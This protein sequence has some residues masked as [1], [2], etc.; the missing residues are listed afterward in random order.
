[1]NLTELK[2]QLIEFNQIQNNNFPQVDT[3]NLIHQ[4]S[5]FYDQRLLDIWQYFG[6]DKREDL[7]L[8]AV[9]GYGRREM[10]PL[11][12]LDI[13]VLVKEPLDEETQTQFNAFFTL[14]WDLKLQVG[15]AIRTFDECI[16]MGKA[17]ISIA[18]NMLEGRFLTGNSQDFYDL[19]ERIHQ[20]DFWITEDFL[21]AKITEKTERYARYHNTSYNL[22]PDL[23]H[24]PG[25]LRDLHLLMWVMLRHYGVYSLSELFEQQLL[26]AEEYSELEQAQA[27][28]FKMRF[29]LHLQLKRYDNRLRFD[30]QLVLSQRLGYQ[31]EGNQ[32]V[33]TMMREYFQATQSIVQLS[34]L[35]LKNFEKVILK[36]A[37]LKSDKIQLD[38]HFYLQNNL[39][40]GT[41]NYQF[42]EDEPRSILDLFYHL[43]RYPNAK[44]SISALRYLRLAIGK[45]T[46]PLCEYSQSRERFISLFSQPNCI[47]RAIKP[48]HHLG[49]LKAYL[50]QWKNITGLMQFNMLH[51]YTVD[52]H[53]IR[54]MQKLEKLLDPNETSYPLCSELFRDFKDPSV[55]YLAAMFHDIAKGQ[56]GCHSEKGAMEVY[57]FA[58]LHNLDDEQTKLMTWLVAEHLTMSMTAQRRDIY[59]PQVISEFAKT[60][61][62]HTA[63]SAL[64]CL[65]FADMSSTNKT[66]WNK[67][68]EQLFT[69]LY[70]ATKEQIERGEEQCIDYQQLSLVNRQRVAEK[71]PAIY[72]EI[73]IKQINTFWNSC[74][75]SYFIR[76][77][78][79][80]LNWHIQGYL[81]AEMQLP[82]ILV[83][84]INQQNM[85][86]LFIHC[87]DMPHFFSTVAQLLTQKKM[88]ILEAQILTNNQLVF[89]SFVVA[90][91]NG[92]PLSETRR[93][94]LKNALF[95]VLNQP[96]LRFKL[97]KKPIKFTPFKH[98]TKVK[99]LDNSH[100][101]QT[102]FE[103]KTLDREGLL[104]HI[105]D[106]FN[107][108]N[109][110]LLNAKI[111]TIGER[112]EDFFVV[113]NS[114][115][116]AL[117][118][119]Q[120]ALLMQ[121]L[122]EE[123]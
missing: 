6:F 123:F 94:Q 62:N 21:Q 88:T 90:E 15:S 41:N 19:L 61:K 55:L 97:I 33:E 47:E 74:P 65:T 5:D 69:Q 35:L 17:E 112:V 117:S 26:F 113:A 29:G 72:D 77:N 118:E 7:T 83:S 93:E 110:Q 40:F 73:Q 50:P 38:N 43:T 70:T 66:F 104:A 106:I 119:E 10:F 20:N 75:D 114:E 79:E 3:L 82:L 51:I 37:K 14:L 100:L 111:T 8:I 48:M 36:K 81:Q 95:N 84:N 63:L 98:K 4:R 1:M 34:Y 9:G 68:K 71:L 30:R 91:Y 32:P 27:V 115:N 92:E 53:T 24:S 11:S 89:D 64:L 76:H 87:Q 54:V 67:W 25:G 105:S 60:V 59:D 108:L 80:Q 78:T 116:K 31:G 42:F 44:P 22:E 16:E 23:K 39:I 103:F 46:T 99:F 52:E 56:S 121:R 122:L 49:V 13:L 109:L 18:T 2:Q 28:L 57:Q 120:K 107:E 58:K 101:E 102:E 45:L 96:K 86:Q 12:D 85:T